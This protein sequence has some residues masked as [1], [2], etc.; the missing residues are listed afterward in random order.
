MSRLDHNMVV[1]KNLKDYCKV[2]TETI[3][4]LESADMLYSQADEHFSTVY[5]Y[6]LCHQAKPQESIENVIKDIDKKL[7]R[8][9]FNI[10][11]LM[12]FMDSK[13]ISEFNRDLE[14]KTPEFTEDNIRTIFLSAY[15][16]KDAMFSRGLVNVFLR[17]SKAHKTNT[18]S[19]FKVNQRAILGYMCDVAFSGHLRVNYRSTNELNDI[20]RI[21]KVLDDK[22][23]QP[24][25]LEGLINNAFLTDNVYEDAYYKIKGFL[26]GNMHF[27]FK[28]EDLLHKANKIIHDYYNGEALA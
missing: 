7:W 27:L 22:Q 12:Q 17:L 26:N 24:R 11:G 6:G 9:A 23:H 1:P 14:D 4:L 2:R 16:T 13:A 10:T 28:R 15:Q 20:D 8:V 3:N 19:P 25:E 21:F 5:E 18:K